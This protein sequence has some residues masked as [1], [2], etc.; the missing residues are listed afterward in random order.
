MSKLVGSV[1]LDS[2]RL[3]APGLHAVP[4]PDFTSDKIESFENW[5]FLSRFTTTPITTVASQRQLNHRVQRKEDFFYLFI[6]CIKIGRLRL[7]IQGKRENVSIPSSATM[8]CYN[9][10]PK[11][12]CRVTYESISLRQGYRTYGTRAQSGNSFCCGLNS[13][14]DKIS[15]KSF[16]WYSYTNT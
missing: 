8:G 3:P 4:K 1:T 10:D 15:F 16:C 5:I 2:Q 13:W 11:V 12:T 9:T 6:Y 7:I 14:T